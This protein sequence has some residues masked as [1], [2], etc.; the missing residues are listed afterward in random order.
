[1]ILYAL[2]PRGGVRGVTMHDTYTYDDSGKKCF[3]N[4]DLTMQL[5]SVLLLQRMARSTVCCNL[6]CGSIG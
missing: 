4:S 3:V 1:M 2:L 5:K 6:K